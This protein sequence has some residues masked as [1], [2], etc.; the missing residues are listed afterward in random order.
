MERKPSSAGH[1][2]K[3]EALARTYSSQ[4][5]QHIPSIQ[6]EKPLSLR[7]QQELKESGH[8]WLCYKV[9]LTSISRPIIDFRSKIDFL[10]L[11]AS[12]IKFA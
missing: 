7:A 10:S 8:W 2:T 3:V 11:M 1:P 6:I 12:R 4:P 5:R 9:S